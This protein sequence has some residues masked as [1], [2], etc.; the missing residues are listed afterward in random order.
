MPTKNIQTHVDTLT[1]NTPKSR[2]R[3]R[4]LGARDSN[5]AQTIA[6]ANER[7]EANAVAAKRKRGAS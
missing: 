7:R 3:I 5:E 4:R 6:H 1:W 2:R